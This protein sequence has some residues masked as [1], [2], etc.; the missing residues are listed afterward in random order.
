MESE[1]EEGGGAWIVEAPS[2]VGIG[3]SRNGDGHVPPCCFSRR[4]S[5]R[6]V[7]GFRGCGSIVGERIVE[8]CWEDTLTRHGWSSS[9]E[10]P[11]QAWQV[12]SVGYVTQDDDA[13]LVVVEAR[14]ETKSGVG[15]DYGCATFV[16][17]SAIRKVTE[18][19]RKR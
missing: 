18:L 15:K 14:G 19:T 5:P 3:N 11:I 2:S 4:C 6:R 8:V 1:A 12:R 7:R 10:L 16:P 17:R 9:D 13:G